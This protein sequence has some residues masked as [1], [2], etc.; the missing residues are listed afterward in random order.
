[1][2][3]FTSVGWRNVSVWGLVGLLVFAAGVALASNHTEEEE[4]WLVFGFRHVNWI[5]RS[6]VKR[7]LRVPWAYAWRFVVE[8]LSQV[9]RI[10]HCF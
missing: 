10:R 7:I 3:K 2:G 8:S 1:M 6:A 9:R 4:L 5:L